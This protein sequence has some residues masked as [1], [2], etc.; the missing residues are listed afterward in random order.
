[1]SK[2]KLPEITVK[3]RPNGYELTIGREGYFYHSL[4]DL[5]AGFIVRVGLNC[6]DVLDVEE[7]HL[8]VLGIASQPNAK[9][10]LNEQRRLMKAETENKPKRKTRDYATENFQKKMSN[11]EKTVRK[12]KSKSTVV[13]PDVL[14]ST[15]DIIKLSID[16]TTLSNR[17]KNIICKAI[18]KT[19]K[20]QPSVKSITL[21]DVS[22]LTCE[23]L[24]T[25][26]GCGG[27]SYWEIIEMLHTYHITLEDEEE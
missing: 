16:N 22:R 24:K 23:V 4:D 25:V 27:A 3:T 5:L 1:M 8:I 26:K 18:E 19:T 14:E 13:H 20:R 21:G 11:I 12:K 10:L 17:A 9:T 6:R 15:N 2:P 7:L